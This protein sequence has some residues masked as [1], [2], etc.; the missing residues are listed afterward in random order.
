MPLKMEPH[1]HI[2]KHKSNVK[3]EQVKDGDLRVCPRKMVWANPSRTSD[4]SPF[5]TRDKN[6]NL[7]AQMENWPFNLKVKEEQAALTIP[8]GVQLVT[9]PTFK[10]WGGATSWM[11][12]AATP[13]CKENAYWKNK[14]REELGGFDHEFFYHHALF[15]GYNV[16][17]ALYN[18]IKEGMGVWGLAPRK[19]ITNVLPTTVENAPSQAYTVMSEAGAKIPG[20]CGGVTPPTEKT[21]QLAGQLNPFTG[22]KFLLTVAHSAYRCCHGACEAQGKIVKV[23]LW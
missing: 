2:T 22:H 21:R 16:T 4:K 15:V 19:I 8:F 23:Q 6:C 7:Y 3:E 17:N 1:Y 14:E 11:G 5:G 18:T 20:G 13:K 10:G 9:K 12:V